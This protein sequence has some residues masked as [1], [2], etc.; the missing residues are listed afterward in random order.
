MAGNS[1]VDSIYFTNL[2]CSQTRYIFNFFPRLTCNLRSTLHCSVEN[3]FF[4]NNSTISITFRCPLPHNI[5]GH[6]LVVLPFPFDESFFVFIESWNSFIIV[7]KNEIR[8]VTSAPNH[9]MIPFMSHSKYM[10]STKISICS[11]T[12]KP[13]PSDL[14]VILLFPCPS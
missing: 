7:G 8:I 10:A 12:T 9:L 13:V 11:V 4:E 1:N 14:T 6:I 2:H 3:P 5:Y